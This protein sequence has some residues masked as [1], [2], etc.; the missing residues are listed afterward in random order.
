MLH[1][2]FCSFLKG[3]LLMLQKGSE[4]SSCA[5]ELWSQPAWVC[6]VTLRNLLDRSA[7]RFLHRKMGIMQLSQRS[8]SGVE[9]S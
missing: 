8:W 1:I 4:T 2:Q 9:M 7:P 5:Y 3:S 6:G